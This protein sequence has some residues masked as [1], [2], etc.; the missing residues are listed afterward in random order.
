MSTGIGKAGAIGTA[1]A[2][3]T[4]ATDPFSFPFSFLFLCVLLKRVLKRILCVLYAFYV[5]TPSRSFTPG[6][7]FTGVSRRHGFLR[8]VE[9]LVVLKGGDLT[10]RGSLCMV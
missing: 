4:I 6:P 2:T 1:G 7:S 5:V 8:W 10:K 3:V 9:I